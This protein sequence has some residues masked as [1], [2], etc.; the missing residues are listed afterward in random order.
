MSPVSPLG[1]AYFG[2]IIAKL[3][4]IRG[5]YHYVKLALSL[6][7]KVGSRESAG[8]VICV[9]THVRTYLE[10]LQSVLEYFNDGYTAAMTSGDVS[11]ATANRAQTECTSFFSGANLQTMREKYAKMMEMIEE[12]KQVVIL[13]QTLPV[14][15]SIVRLVG[16]EEKQ[17]Y[18]IEEQNI[19]ARNNSAL[20]SY[21][22]QKAYISFIFRSYD[23]T[24]I[25][26]ESYFACS[27]TTW[28]NLFFHHAAQS[29]Y[30]GLISFWVARKSREELRQQWYQR[31]NKSKLAL[32]QWAESS[33]W[34]FEHKWY[35]L[36]AEEAFCNSEFE[37]AKF[38]DE[39]AISSATDHKVR[40]DCAALCLLY[41]ICGR[42]NS[43][44]TFLSPCHVLFIYSS[45]MKRRWH[46]SLQGTSIWGWGRLLN[47]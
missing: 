6:L 28:A 23:D 4:D 11:M 17:K 33:R 14:Q 36:E 24:K 20:R 2:S 47:Q 10:P 31:G 19:I 8:E 16:S 46:A 37:S 34:N 30:I 21:C 15:R 1:F 45:S 44:L 38:F 26:S 32:K 5:G 9:G 43:I 18:V 12:T 42:Y 41:R 27:E 40:L 22:F 3:G 13:V 25:A 29:F 39:K 7:D 35:L